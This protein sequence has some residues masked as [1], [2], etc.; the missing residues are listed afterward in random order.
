MNLKIITSL[1]IILLA[2]STQAQS[3][4]NK[5]SAEVEI[6][7]ANKGIYCENILSDTTVTIN[8]LAISP[9]LPEWLSDLFNFFGLN[10]FS[11]ISSDNELAQEYTTRQE[12]WN[13]ITLK[14]DNLYETQKSIL[15]WLPIMDQ[16][17]NYADFKLGKQSGS[18]A[19]TWAVIGVIP[20]DLVKLKG[21]GINKKCVEFAKDFT[22]KIS[23]LLENIGFTVN[24]MEIKI[25]NK[26]QF[27]IL[28][29]GESIT[30]NGMHQFIEVVKDGKSYIF[31]NLN[32]NG[33]AKEN[34]LRYLEIANPET[35]ALVSGNGVLNYV[36]KIS[37]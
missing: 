10:P 6:L 27:G 1:I 2:I 15:S 28:Y 23:P 18:S 11:T 16:Y 34:W 35:G 5:L 13:S 9:S 20:Y 3:S 22:K 30:D 8:K 25:I 7:S 19:V 29:R 21:A 12:A 32:P 26:F 24:K 36:T 33:I 37:K 4:F 17:Y 14:V 31:D